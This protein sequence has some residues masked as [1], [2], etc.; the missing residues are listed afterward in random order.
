MRR[1]A[2][3]NSLPIYD[4]AKSIPKSMDYFYDD[5]HFNENGAYTAGTGL[6]TY[7]VGNKLV[8]IP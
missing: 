1:V 6:A 5:F 8:H 2:N 4:L 7:L 3:E